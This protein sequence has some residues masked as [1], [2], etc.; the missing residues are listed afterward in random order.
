[1]SQIM[2]LIHIRSFTRRLAS[3]TGNNLE[4][5]LHYLPKESG[6]PYLFSFLGGYSRTP[7][8]N[9]CQKPNDNFEINANRP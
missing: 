4:M 3:R 1:M 2:P 7:N 5:R 6:C 9:L 8:Q